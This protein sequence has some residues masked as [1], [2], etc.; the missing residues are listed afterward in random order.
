MVPFAFY[1]KLTLKSF[2]TSLAAPEV[3]QHCSAEPYTQN[4]IEDIFSVYVFLIVLFGLRL[5][6]SFEFEDYL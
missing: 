1:F 5:K 3:S 4:Q 2:S 6:L